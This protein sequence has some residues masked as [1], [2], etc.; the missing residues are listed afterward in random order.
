MVEYYSRSGK[1][2]DF[3]E[4][5]RLFGAE[6][7]LRKIEVTKVGEVTISTV[8]LVID[9]SFGVGPPVIFETMVFGGE[10]DEYMQRYSTE[11]AALAGHDQIVMSIKNGKKL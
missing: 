5:M 8:H 3:V 6:N 2:I 4:A 7:D 11:A 9:H 1:E 10:N